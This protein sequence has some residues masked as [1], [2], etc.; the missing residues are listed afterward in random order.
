MAK[1]PI[2]Y[3]EVA[4]IEAFDAF[5]WYR[6]R[7]VRVAENFQREL[8]QAQ[9]AIQNSP[10]AW[11]TYLSGTRHYLL[12]RYPYVVVYRILESRIEIVAVAH[13][14]REPEYWV[15]RLQSSD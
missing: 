13:T 10:E 15:D 7:S 8:E 1:L 12:K 3:H 5:D 6:V 9:F 11:P 2:D 4:R 14:R